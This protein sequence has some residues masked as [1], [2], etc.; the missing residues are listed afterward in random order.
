[1]P[2][3]DFDSG[4]HLY[5]DTEETNM[6]NDE[7]E[8]APDRIW[9]GEGLKLNVGQYESVSIDLGVSCAIREGETITDAMKR[10][11][12]EVTRELTQEALRVR[13]GKY[14]K[15]LL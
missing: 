3:D 13:E 15:V 12:A 9:F 11:R 7:Q 6:P 1:M 4:D 5:R 10:V 2:N 8:N 14:K